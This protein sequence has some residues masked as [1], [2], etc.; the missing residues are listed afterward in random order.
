M[1]ARAREIFLSA[2]LLLAALHSNVHAQQTVHGDLVKK[3]RN[4]LADVLSM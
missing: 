1:R 3:A 2:G 4:P